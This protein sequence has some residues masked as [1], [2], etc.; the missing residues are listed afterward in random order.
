MPPM[1]DIFGGIELI[2]AECGLIAPFTQFGEK[3]SEHQGLGLGLSIA[4]SVA[5]TA[6]GRLLVSPS[7]S[8]EGL[9]VT[10]DLPTSRP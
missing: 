3:Q 6:G 9:H 4:R 2:E 5:E 1:N 10:F 8:G 7:G